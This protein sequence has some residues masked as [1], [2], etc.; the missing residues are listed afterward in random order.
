MRINLITDSACELSESMQKATDRILI[1][2]SINIGDKSYVDDGSIDLAEL[3]RAMKEY[4]GVPK[5]AAPSPYDFLKAFE[6]GAESFAVTISSNLSATYSN[7]MLAKKMAEEK[8]N[9]LIH[10]FDSKSAVCG[11]TIIVHKIKEFLDL[12]LQF[13]EIVEKVEAFIE[14]RRTI[15]VLE[16]LD[17]LM[18]N[19]RMSKLAGFFAN[20]LSIKPVLEA[21]NNGEIRLVEKTRGL[22]KAHSKLVELIGK[23]KE[24]LKERLLVITH[25]NAAKAAEDIRDEI[26]SLY[27]P[28]EVQILETGGLSTIYADNGGIVIAY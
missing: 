26:I 6:K 10:V 17:N 21:D 28:K 7:A 20:V 8:G 1:P 15:F 19:G 22:K 2:F 14:T 13:N 24:L 11:E 3:R 4:N 12:G 16:S 18:K 5:T 27:N 9:K 25:C 23:D